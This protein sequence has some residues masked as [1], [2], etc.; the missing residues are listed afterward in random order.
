MGLKSIEM[1][2]H[3]GNFKIQD[4]MYFIYKIIFFNVKRV[5]ENVLK[6]TFCINDIISRNI[7]DVTLIK[8]TD[9]KI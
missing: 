7:F 6:F 1:S 5:F 3:I 9:C 4:Y 8:L 2:Q